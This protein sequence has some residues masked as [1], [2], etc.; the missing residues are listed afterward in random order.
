MQVK[1]E[2]GFIGNKIREN[3]EQ[4]R[5]PA[6]IATDEYVKELKGVKPLRNFAKTLEV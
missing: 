6:V 1:L 3:V 5:L 2:F 4:G